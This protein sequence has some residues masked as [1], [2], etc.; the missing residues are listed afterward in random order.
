M[1]VL[2]ASFTVGDSSFSFIVIRRSFY[3]LASGANISGMLKY[4]NNYRVDPKKNLFTG[5]PKLAEDLSLDFA[6]EAR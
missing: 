3:G 5:A 2:S 6:G 4:V 1:K